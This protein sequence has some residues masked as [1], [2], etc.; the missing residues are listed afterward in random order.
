MAKKFVGYMIADEMRKDERG[1]YSAVWAKKMDLQQLMGLDAEIVR[2]EVRR[3]P[4]RASK[5][6]EKVQP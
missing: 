2:V 3:I 5:G 1:D 4:E 6:K